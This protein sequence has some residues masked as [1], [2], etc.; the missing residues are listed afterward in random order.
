MMHCSVHAAMRRASERNTVDGAERLCVRHASAVCVRV[1]VR[2]GTEHGG[3]GAR[4]RV[5]P[6][7]DGVGCRG[8]GWLFVVHVVEVDLDLIDRSRVREKEN[9][10]N[11][12][13]R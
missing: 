13:I 9:S 5:S 3:V 7:G 11:G 8:V 4:S 12:T 6:V 10:G 2:N 1:L